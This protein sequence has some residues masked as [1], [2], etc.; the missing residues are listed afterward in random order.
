[1]FYRSIS[2]PDGVE[3]REENVSVTYWEIRWDSSPI[4]FVA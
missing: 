1:M 3:L 4:N 2:L